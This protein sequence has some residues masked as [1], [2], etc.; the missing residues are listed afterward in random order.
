ML[1]L[2]LITWLRFVLWLGVGLIVYA[3]F[4]ARHSRLNARIAAAAPSCGPVTVPG[5]P[6]HLERT[7][8]DVHRTVAGR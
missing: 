3:N 7:R 8:E 2:P 6:D 5:A 1:N 4:G